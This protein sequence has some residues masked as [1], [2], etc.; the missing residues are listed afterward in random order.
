MN[1]GKKILYLMGCLAFFNCV[2]K[3]DKTTTN[4]AFLIKGDVKGFGSGMAAMYVY[5]VVN[6]KPIVL[7][8]VFVTD[9][10]F[11]VKG[12]IKHPDQVNIRLNQQG[13][14]FFLENSEITIKGDATLPREENQPIEVNLEGSPLNNLFERQIAEE[15]KIKNDS[16]YDQLRAVNKAYN[17]ASQA[18]NR[19]LSKQL[20]DSIGTFKALQEEQSKRIKKAKVAFVKQHPTSPAASNVMGYFF[21]ERMF[22]LEEMDT[23]I[24]LFQGRAKQ[25]EMYKYIAQEYEDIN[26]TRPG[27]IAPDFTLKTPEGKDLSLSSTKGKYVL[28]DFWASWCGPCRASYPHLK[29]VY[30]KYK[31]KGFEVLAVS[32]DSKH[33]AWKKAIKED[34]TTWLHVVDTFNR[35]GFPSDIGS[36]YGIPY[37]PT[38]YLLDQEGK[39]LAKNLTPDE[40]DAKLVEIFG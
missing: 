4:D 3:A 18:R 12:T 17:E 19:A 28:I 14:S 1:R 32:T 37:L 23:L 21:S 13:F 30:E 11:E 34:G 31:N 35:P 22:S 24:S 40:L 27:A 38:T 8:S 10:K 36:L 29:K 2:E 7:D 9:G 16:K 6:R 25:T 39:V 15:A 26:R 5:D 20:Y 33:D